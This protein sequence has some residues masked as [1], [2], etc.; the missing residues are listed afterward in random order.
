V[1]RAVAQPVLAGVVAAI[2]GFASSFAIVIAGLRAV[3]ASRAQVASGLLVLC[4]G[5]G[6][7]GVALCWRSRMPASIA[8]STPGAALLIAT[9]PVHGGYAAALGAF[10]VAGMLAV[11][12]G[13]AR[14]FERAVSSIPP[15]IASALLA[16]VLLPICLAPA[17]AVVAF[18][19][20]T[21]PV[22]VGWLVLRRLWR[23]VAVPGALVAAG[24]AVALDGRLGGGAFA[25]ALPSLTAVIPR[26]DPQTIVSLGLPLFLV[27]M[28]SQ[29]LAGVSVLTLH[30]YRPRLRPILTS[31]GTVST[32]IAPFGGHG[33]NLA[34][35]TAAL[36]AGPDAG[37]DPGRRWI[38]GVA[39][40][41]TFL[42]LAPAAG[43]AAAL[44]A[45]TPA[46]LVDA[47]AGLALLDALSG[48]L[49]S[50]LDHPVHRDAALITFLVTASGITALGLD[51]PVLGLAAGCAVLAANTLG[52]PDSSTESSSGAGAGSDATL[53][54]RT[55]ATARE[56]L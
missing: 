12:A 9:G 55:G 38:A 11:V 23:R 16:G 33:I 52:R 32:A 13:I 1:S 26:F 30:G 37:D 15:A 27:T 25:H 18:P 22:I 39:N 43:L 46:A 54:P 21:A 8:W 28:A 31:T 40:G 53:R 29:N 50:A 20:L 2:V 24:V 34:A 17:R 51:A 5:M 19:V 3:G 42:L 48:A 49:A 47:I 44:I 7:T 6:I 36:M 45:R 14:P 4:V 41:A 56:C 10:A 35:I